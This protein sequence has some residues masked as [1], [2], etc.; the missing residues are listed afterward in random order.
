MDL[1]E[2]IRRDGLLSD[3]Q[4]MQVKARVYERGEDWATAICALKLATEDVMVRLLARHTGYPGLDLSQS[5][6][7]LRVAELIPIDVARRAKVLSV[8]DAT[9]GLVVAMANPD[10][11]ATAEE[12]G[13]MTGRKVLRHVAVPGL[14]LSA[15]DGL[16]KVRAL[17]EQEWR[18]KEAWSFKPGPEGRAGVI[19]PEPEEA[20]AVPEPPSGPDASSLLDALLSGPELPPRTAID[21]PDEQAARTT[22]RTDLGA[23]KVV[24][25]VDDDA[26][27]RGLEAKLLEPFGCA[28][29]QCGD[30]LLAL[31]Q[32]RELKPNLIVLDAML[33]GMHGFEVCRAIKGDPALR[34]IPILMVSGVHTGWQVG[35]D[36]SEVYGAD[37]FFEKPFKA[38]DFTR[39]VRRLLM[40]GSSEEDAAKA[41]RQS[42]L[43]TCKQ[44]AAVA[45]A[46]KLSEAIDLLQAAAA[47]D[48]YSAEPHFYL[49]Q[50]FARTG[51]TYRALAALERAAGLRPDLEPPLTQL[52]ELYLQLGFRKTAR[53][54]LRRA[55]DVCKEPARRDDLLAR[56]A[57][58]P[59]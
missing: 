31:S 36:V 53:E 49:G 3:A 46:G 55:A 8:M 44:A 59:A 43:A 27:M 47:K 15:L 11:R 1:F 41:R 14:L 25:V 45:R 42:A 34:S 35:V 12:I 2:R 5:V 40:A 54:V 56:V 33:P 51:D 18:G 23:G 30:G 16:A 6:I 9:G 52:G 29:L 32:A 57:R 39:A 13:F 19:R 58:I 20:P 17:G 48:P 22:K 26:E 10:D 50:L 24:L 4:L 38:D 7:P 28:I 21:F 37:G